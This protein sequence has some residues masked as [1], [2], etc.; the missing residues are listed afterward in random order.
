MCMCLELPLPPKMHFCRSPSNVPRLPSFLQLPQNHHV[1]LTFGKVRNPLGLPQKRRLN[2]Q[3]W[4]EHMV[5]VAFYFEMCCA[6]QRR[7]C[8]RHLNFQ[9][10]SECLVFQHFAFKI[11][12]APQPRALF[13]H[14]SFQK[15]FK[16]VVFLAPTAK[17]TPILK[18]FYH[19]DIEMCFAP[20]A[21]ALLAHRKFQK[22]PE[23]EVFL[24]FLLWNVFRA[25]AVCAFPTFNFQTWSEIGAFL[26][27]LTSTCASRHSGAQF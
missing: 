26:R 4:C 15:W 13:R 27:I 5:H 20:Q 10:R 18:C 1:L 14:L 23:A 6:P 3:K 17:S 7:A 22:C 8:F 19:F 11:C 2:V 16:H 25:A 21:R 12:F 24:Q 9:K